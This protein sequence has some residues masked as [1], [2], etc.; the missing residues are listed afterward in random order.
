MNA[1]RADKKHYSEVVSNEVARAL[2]E[3][4]RQLGLANTVPTTSKLGH[5]GGERRIAG[6]LGDKKVDVTCATD[7]AGLILAVSVKTISFPDQKTKNYQKNLQNR[8]AD[9][10]FEVTTLHKRFPYAVV[11]GLFLLYED[12]KRDSFSKTRVST[13]GARPPALEDVYG[14][15]GAKERRVEIRVPGSR[16]L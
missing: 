15:H 2:A 14:T 5:Q 10:A 4:F 3:Q 6:G 13:F 7:A 9:L 12:A 1:S 11:G 8:K 16:T